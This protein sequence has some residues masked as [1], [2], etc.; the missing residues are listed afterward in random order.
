M[1]KPRL[2]VV[3]PDFNP[4]GGGSLVAAFGVQAL[5]EEYEVELLTWEP[6]DF[7]KIDRFFGTRL[8]ETKF[9][10]HGFSALVRRI[11]A[12]DPDPYTSQPVGFLVRRTKK[13]HAQYDFVLSFCDE[14]DLGGVGL[15]Y[16]YYPRFGRLYGEMT[17]AHS[18]WTKLRVH[19]R[20]FQLISNFSFE[21]M[22]PNVTLVVS[23][24]TGEHTR[25]IY[26]IP[27]KTVY[28][29]VVANFPYV[30]WEARENGFV[31]IGRISGE[32]RFENSIA[33][34]REL[35]TRGHAVHLHIVGTHGPAHMESYYRRICRLVEQHSDW[36]SLHEN[37]SRVEL[38]E[39]IAAHRYGI[40][41]MTDEHFGLAPAEMVRGGCIVFVP[42][43]GGQVEIVG[44]DE[45]LIYNS[46]DDA[47]EKITHILES[48]DMQSELQ[49]KLLTRAELFS[50]E[51]FMNEIQEIVAHSLCNKEL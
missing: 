17:G 4:P 9:V 48:A 27:T 11:V 8:S 47:V 38:Y 40:H 35:R 33:I 36:V 5:C 18:R 21:R 20:P 10:T 49:S 30:P 23:D 3:R 15:Q 6:I 34:V 44:R 14:M 51:R 22:K 41:S 39:M 19:Y 25:Q 50:V 43:N 45:R 24:W 2:L 7:G 29:P 26:S 46:I 1:K 13:M 16:I 31:C 12:L 37:L 28:P 32:K 42:N